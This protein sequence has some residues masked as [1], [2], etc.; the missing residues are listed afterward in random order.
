MVER[1]SHQCNGSPQVVEVVAEQVAGQLEPLLQEPLIMRPGGL[2]QV[3]QKAFGLMDKSIWSMI[4]FCW[5]WSWTWRN[6]W[7]CR[8]GG[9]GG[10]GAGIQELHN[11]D[12]WTLILAVEVEVEVIGPTL[13][14][15]RWRWW[16]RNRSNKIQIPKLIWIYK[17][18]QI[19]YKENNYGTFCKTRI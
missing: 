15:Q 9:I 7:N 5:W 2:V 1:K 3:V 12:A 13:Q 4:F 17:Q 19:R 10:G 11:A 16:F 6:S 18:Q 14:V 8:I